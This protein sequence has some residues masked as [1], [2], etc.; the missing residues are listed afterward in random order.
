MKK[1]YLCTVMLL[2]MV[3]QSY[4]QDILHIKKYDEQGKLVSDITLEDK[5]VANYDLEK[6]V[7]E[8][9]TEGRMTIYGSY[10]TGDIK[11]SVFFDSNNQSGTLCKNEKTVLR[12]TLGVGGCSNEDFTGFVI[13]DV[14]KNSPADKLGLIK[15]DVISYLND[16]PITSYC[17]LHIAVRG[18][19]VGDVVD[20]EYRKNGK[21]LIDEVTMAGKAYKTITFGDCS[22]ENEDI[23]LQQEQ[24]DLAYTT[25]LTIYPNPSKELTYLKY[26]SDSNEPLT[27]FVMDGNGALL[28]QE[29]VESFH[30][31]LR[32]SYSFDGQAPGM[33]FFVVQQGELSTESKVMYIGN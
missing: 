22:I 7:N 3:L 19:S 16:N 29:H 13:K 10:M 33:Y 20:L 11:N 15:G 1:M 9:Q 17:D 21:T 8:S 2:M 23:N 5:D 4:S 26:D 12:A 28:Y 24:A 30:G 14:A 6:H 25:N 27:Y 32:A 31:S 18:T